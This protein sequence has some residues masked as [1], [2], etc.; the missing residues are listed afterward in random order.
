MIVF[1][2]PQP[3]QNAV[4]CMEIATKIN[5]HKSLSVPVLQFFSGQAMANYVQAIALVTN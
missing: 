2:T 5:T 3:L 1:D 4:N